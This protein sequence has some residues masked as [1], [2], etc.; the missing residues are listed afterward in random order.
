[1]KRVSLTIGT[2]GSA[3]ALAQTWI[4]MEMLQKLRDGDQK[5]A[6]TERIIRTSGDGSPRNQIPPTSS[7]KD[8]FTRELDEALRSGEIDIAVHSLKD[9]PIDAGENDGITIAAF[10]PR[11]SPLDVLI[12]RAGG[13]TIDTL[14]EGARV[15]TSSIRR[16]VQL[17]SWRSDLDIREMHGNVTTRIKKLRA[18]ESELDGIVLAEAGLKRLKIGEEIDEVISKE[19]VLPAPG[20]GCLAV[21]V[22]SNDEETKSIV[23][24]IDD[25]ETRKCVAAERVFS[26][27]LGGGCNLPIAALATLREGEMTIEGMLAPSPSML[28]GTDEKNL[29]RRGKINGP[30]QKGEDLGRQLARDLKMQ[31]PTHR[32]QR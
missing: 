6:L 24:R 2:R 1:M 3:L 32:A 21:S 9:V 8:A 30:S 16:S 15:G 14:P 29:L 23:R 13:K 26:R 17:K 20:Q 11:E 28:R 4:V 19:I 25:N 31:V 18:P 27:E 22:R 7:G 10:P 12:S 5:L